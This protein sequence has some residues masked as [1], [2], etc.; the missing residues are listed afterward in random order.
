MVENF[1]TDFNYSCLLE[2]SQNATVKNIWLSLSKYIAVLE[3]MFFAHS[4]KIF[5]YV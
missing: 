5:S 2:D 1:S 4:I 3:M